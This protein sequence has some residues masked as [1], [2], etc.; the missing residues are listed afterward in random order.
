MPDYYK[1]VIELKE[2]Q[3]KLTSQEN[4]Q[5]II[6]DNVSFHYIELFKPIINLQ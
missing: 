1:T 5:R 3:Q 2:T 6:Y 4:E